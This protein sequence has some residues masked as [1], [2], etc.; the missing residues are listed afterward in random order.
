MTAARSSTLKVTDD[1]DCIEQFHRNGWTDGLPVV[2]PT[3]AR[4]EQFL[5][6]AGRAADELVGTYDMRSRP[7]TVEKIAINAIMAGCLPE[8]LNTVVALVDC[9]LE[10]QVGLHVANSSTGSLA[11]GFVV[12]G[13]I[14]H[15]LAMN[16][17]G[18]VLGP[19]NR[20]N[21]SIGRSLRLIQQNVMGS[22]AGAGGPEHNQLPILDRSTIGT[23]AKY[24][25]YHIVE[26]EEAFPELEPLHVTLGF[27]RE[28]SVVTAFTLGNHIMMSNHHEKSPEAWVETIAHYIV[29][30]GRLDDGGFGVLIVPP[31]PAEILVKHG[32]SKRDVATAV[33]ERTRRS[34]AWVKRNGFKIGGRYERGGGGNY[35]DEEGMLGAA[36]SPEDIHVVIAGGPAGN[37]PTFLQTYASVF[38]PASR[39]LKPNRED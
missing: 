29:T 14:R 15:E 32:W 34:T 22:I 6:V 27:E 26:N 23:P 31:E 4:L 20:A 8:H 13:P 25:A 33:F 11:L 35:G 17:H 28:D 24:A 36:S 7:I 10:P 1:A 12:N 18:N 38:R 30:A 21:A 5:A 19:G 3:Q 9:L 39:K 2:P 16:F 37:F